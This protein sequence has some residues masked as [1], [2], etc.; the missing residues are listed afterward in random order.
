M[1]SCSGVSTSSAPTS[2]FGLMITAP[3]L[4]VS[5]TKDQLIRRTVAG[6]DYFPM[7][8]VEKMRLRM[9]SAVVAPVRASMAC[10][11]P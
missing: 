6:L 11:A 1:A 3:L 5:S 4:L 10:K 9:S 7:Q 2:F 8:N